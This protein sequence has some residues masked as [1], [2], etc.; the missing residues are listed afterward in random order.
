MVVHQNLDAPLGGLDR[1]L[2][3]ALALESVVARAL[4]VH[5]CELGAL[6]VVGEA[7]RA[8][9]LPLGDEHGGS[10][11]VGLAL[12]DEPELK[13]A[14]VDA[15]ECVVASVVGAGSAGREK[16]RAERHFGKRGSSYFSGPSKSI[17]DGWLG[18]G[19]SLG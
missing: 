11:G 15:A 12:E 19:N 16:C 14:V 10:A 18:N 7:H 2:G 8:P 4:P 13:L 5:G 17:L 9:H 1:G 3:D 6:C